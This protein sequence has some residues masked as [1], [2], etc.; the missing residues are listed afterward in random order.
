MGTG[1]GPPKAQTY[2]A[3]QCVRRW[4]ICDVVTMRVVR[5]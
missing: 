5:I 3:A 2:R 4:G 1:E